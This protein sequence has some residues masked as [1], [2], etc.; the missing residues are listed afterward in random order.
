MI[1]GYDSFCL[2][3]E[4]YRPWPRLRPNCVE[5]RR[6]YDR[7][8]ALAARK[9]AWLVNFRGQHDGPQ[10]NKIVKKVMWVLGGSIQ[11]SLRRTAGD[12]LESCGGT[13][14]TSKMSSDGKDLTTKIKCENDSA[15]RSFAVLRS[16]H[17][18]IQACHCQV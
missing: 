9:K 13:L 18:N 10:Y 4:G 3:D 12:Y 16:M 15:E 11:T 5:C 17:K 14:A 7:R 6:W 2:L 8:D 1:K